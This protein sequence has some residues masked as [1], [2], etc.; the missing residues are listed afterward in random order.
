MKHSSARVFRS[1]KQASKEQHDDELARTVRLFC[2]YFSTMY[3]WLV[4]NFAPVSTCICACMCSIQI[5]ISS[6]ECKHSYA[7][8][9]IIFIRLCIQSTTKSLSTPADAPDH[10]GL[11]HIS[12]PEE[13]HLLLLLLMLLLLADA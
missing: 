7:L 2:H 9:I 8:L 3:T 13:P 4:L 5:T 11:R 6:L 1:S 12:F 10:M